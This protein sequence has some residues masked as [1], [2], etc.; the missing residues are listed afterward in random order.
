MTALV[1]GD[2]S[3]PRCRA[4]V[5]GSI[6]Q[7]DAQNSATWLTSS[8]VINRGFYNSHG[9]E[10]VGTV[11]IGEGDADWHEAP[12]VLDVVSIN[13]IVVFAC[14]GLITTVRVED[15]QGAAGRC[16]YSGQGA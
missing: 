14:S 5:D 3:H 11:T 4:T 13:G 10:T 7:A 9:F 12:V 6:L 8:N 15:G 1:C 16:R 2:S